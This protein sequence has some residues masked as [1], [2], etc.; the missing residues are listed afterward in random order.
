MHRGFLSNSF[1]LPN[2]HIVALYTFIALLSDLM[3]VIDISIPVCTLCGKGQ[4][5]DEK[6]DQ[7]IL[8]FL[9]R[10]CHLLGSKSSW[11]M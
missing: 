1:A 6:Y 3:L 2:T 4:N 7:C 11:L 8:Y 9:R 10:P 5:I